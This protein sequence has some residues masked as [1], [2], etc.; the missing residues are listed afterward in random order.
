[1]TDGSFRTQLGEGFEFSSSL[2]VSLQEV[3]TREYPC[4]DFQMESYCKFGYLFTLGSVQHCFEISKK[5]MKKNFSENVINDI[6]RLERTCVGLGFYHSSSISVE[7][8][9]RGKGSFTT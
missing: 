2:D 9:G 7:R 8:F 1:M 6:R 4:P 3:W 5:E